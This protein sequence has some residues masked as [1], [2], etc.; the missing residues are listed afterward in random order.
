MKEVVCAVC[1]KTTLS[2]HPTRKFCSSKCFGASMRGPNS[3]SRDHKVFNEYISIAEKA[4]GHKLPKGAEIHHFNNDHT[5]NRPSNLVICESG[6]YH[7]LLHRRASIAARGGDP[8]TQSFCSKCGQIK[9]LGEFWTNKT[10]KH[11]GYPAGY[12]KTCSA[13]AQK[14]WRTRKAEAH[15]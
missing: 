12:C 3:R 10:G 14:M 13:A 4:L 15:V 2:K 11:R 7:K 6:R 9:S 8:N 1:G 5:D